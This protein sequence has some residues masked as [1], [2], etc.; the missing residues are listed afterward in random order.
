MK[1]L[2]KKKKLSDLFLSEKEHVENIKRKRP[3]LYKLLANPTPKA[4]LAANIYRLRKA[5]KI[6]QKELADKAGIGLKTF[7]RI[8][9]AQPD[10][11]PTMDA[12]AGLAKAVGVDI[13]ELYEHIEI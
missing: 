2:V 11:N 5:R 6:T 7:Q 1:T 9:T 3:D 10:S 13:Q 12:I 4:R 8:E